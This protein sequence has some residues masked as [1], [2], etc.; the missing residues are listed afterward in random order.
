MK[1]AENQALTAELSTISSKGYI[2]LCQTCEG[3]FKPKKKRQIFCSDR[4][5]LLHWAASTLVKEYKAGNINGLR[6]LLQE[7]CE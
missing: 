3:S 2:G 4:C 5:R 1:M 6:G 7:L